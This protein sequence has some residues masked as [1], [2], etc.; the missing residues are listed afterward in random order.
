MVVLGLGQAMS[1]GGEIGTVGYR[2]KIEVSGRSVR[3]AN[4]SPCLCLIFLKMNPS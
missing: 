4:A 2:V 1:K 3:L